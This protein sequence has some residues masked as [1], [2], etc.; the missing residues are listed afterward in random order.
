MASKRNSASTDAS[1]SLAPTSKK[2]RV[3]SGSQVTPHPASHTLEQLLDMDHQDL[4][5]YA[6][7]IQGA[8]AAAQL[9]ALEEDTIIVAAPRPP[10]MSAREIRDKAVELRS[11]IHRGVKKLMKWQNS[12]KLGTSRWSFSTGVASEEVVLR[13]FR[14]E[15]EKKLWKQKKLTRAE[16]EAC[17]GE[18]E[19]SIRFGYL[20]ITSKHVTLK[21]N[22]DDNTF[23]ACGQYGKQELRYLQEAEEEGSAACQ[24]EAAAVY[25]DAAAEEAKAVAEKAKVAASDAEVAAEE[26]VAAVTA[27]LRG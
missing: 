27:L 15:K 2:R 11:R 24:A 12:C 5:E 23:T 7:G 6:F 3:G 19:K 4:A 22:A 20:A 8:L 9:P 13:A 10:V 25:A 26:A 21:W 18:I 1:A 16:F 17:V 14:L